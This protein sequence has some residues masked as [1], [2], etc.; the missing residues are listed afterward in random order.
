MTQI[1]V[2]A[3]EITGQRGII[4]KGWGG[5]VPEPKDFIYLLDNCPH[6]WLFLQCMAVGMLRTNSIDSPELGLILEAFRIRTSTM[7]WRFYKACNPTF[8][9]LYYR[10]EL[11]PQLA[12]VHHGGAGTTAA[13]LKAA[14]P[15]TVVPFFGDQPFWGD[16]VHARG[17][18]PHPIP[19]DQFTLPSLVDAINFML[20][21]VVKERAVELAKAM[22]SEDGGFANAFAPFANGFALLSNHTDIFATLDL[23]KE[24]VLVVFAIP[25]AYFHL[26]CVL[27]P[28]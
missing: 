18:G 8:G 19:V 3:L 10:P 23:A 13:G 22:E 21:P 16:R 11:D 20:D 27:I 2:E 25:F 17:V 1:I 12:Q 24:L 9:P 14:C 26:I 5:L 15:T 28:I 7:P 4:N 6:D